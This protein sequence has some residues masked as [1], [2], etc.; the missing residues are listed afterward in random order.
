VLQRF[1]QRLR[2][3]ARIGDALALHAEGGGDL[4]VIGFELYRK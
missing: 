1:F 4:G 2:D 3:L